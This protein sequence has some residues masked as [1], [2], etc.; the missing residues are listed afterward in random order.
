MTIV[1]GWRDDV[2]PVENSVRYAKQYNA[3]L[4]ILDGDHRLVDE[5]SADQLSVRVLP[6]DAGAVPLSRPSRLIIQPR[7]RHG[8]ACQLVRRHEVLHH[9]FGKQIEAAAILVRDVVVKRQLIELV[10]KRHLR[11]GAQRLQLRVAVKIAPSPGRASR[12]V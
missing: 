4:H 1:H 6:G 10:A 3:A 2:I 8:A 7:W 5:H 9:G 12:N 11:L